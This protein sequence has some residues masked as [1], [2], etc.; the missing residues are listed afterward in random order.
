MP[1]ETS[2]ND[3]SAKLSGYASSQRV[4]GR[5][6]YD[7]DLDGDLSDHLALLFDTSHA[8]VGTNRLRAYQDD[9]WMFANGYP[10][11]GGNPDRLWSHVD[12]EIR[13]PAFRLLE[14]D[15]LAEAFYGAAPD[16]ST[17]VSA[18]MEFS[19]GSLPVQLA[20][21]NTITH[22][23][24]GGGTV[25]VT[26]PLGGTVDIAIGGQ[27]PTTPDLI[28]ALYG[29]LIEGTDL[30]LQ[31]ISP[32][33]DAPLVAF[34]PVADWQ[35]VDCE[36]LVVTYLQNEGKYAAFAFVFWPDV[37]LPLLSATATIEERIKYLHERLVDLSGLSSLS[38]CGTGS[39]VT[40]TYDLLE[41]TW[42]VP[43]FG[44]MFVSLDGA[45]A[46]TVGMQHETVPAAFNLED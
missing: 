22:Q 30:I 39:Y 7:D 20:K 12:W 14:L 44:Q 37:A 15:G 31:P 2:L 11:E 40:G 13:A 32:S 6:R 27:T 4:F 24:G 18:R 29:I 17:R 25:P 33:Q 45:E 8:A 1:L 23:P 38:V 36:N 42:P 19:L 35:E 5:V 10:P 46:L 9:S 3:R 16:I 21:T 28:P 41:H 43:T 34:S 26:C